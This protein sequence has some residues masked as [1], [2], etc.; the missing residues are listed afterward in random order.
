MEISVVTSP[1]FVTGGIPTKAAKAPFDGDS[2]SGLI[3][4]QGVTRLK[5]AGNA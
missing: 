3:E 2:F 5:I 4:I 1:E